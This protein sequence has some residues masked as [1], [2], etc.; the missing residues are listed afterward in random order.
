[1]KT[2]PLVANV[3]MWKH[4][5]EWKDPWKKFSLLSDVIKARR[6]YFERKIPYGTAFEKSA[7]HKWNQNKK[8]LSLTFV[9]YCENRKYRYAK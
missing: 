7:P 3:D 5:A 6:L 1:M 9:Q 8:I 2:F 4:F